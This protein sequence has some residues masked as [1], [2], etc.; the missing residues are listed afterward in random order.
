[1]HLILK[2]GTLLGWL[3]CFNTHAQKIVL[4]KKWETD[5]ILKVPESVIYDDIQ[6]TIY[7]SNINGKPWEKDRNGF[8][9][10]ITL[11][12]KIEKLEWITGLDAPKGLGI[13]KNKLYIADITKVVIVNIA[14]GQIENSIEI[15]G[16]QTLNDI[17]IDDSGNVY[18]SDSAGK[19]IYL[20]QG[21]KATVWAENREWKRPN[22]L[23]ALKNS[24]RLVDADGGTFYNILYSNKASK[25]T[26]EGLE[27]GDGIVEIVPDE[28]V[29]SNW[30]GEINY[31]KDTKVERI[32]NTKEAKRNAAD[33]WYIPSEKLLLIP[34]FFGNTVAAYQL[35]KN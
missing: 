24:I 29:I 14:T 19:K 32:L 28:Y 18:I 35:N 13:F 33:I 20:L 17:T 4:E 3:M 12:G 31:V 30:N 34:T 1:M 2:T 26:A 6:K 15:K 21:D 11:S 16:A 8:I 9:S 7:A 25:T 27:K 10:K 22:G 5:S 23:L